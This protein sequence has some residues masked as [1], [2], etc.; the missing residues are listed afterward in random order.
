MQGH[1]H[2][3]QLYNWR[4]TVIFFVPPDNIIVTPPKFKKKKDRL[5]CGEQYAWIFFEHYAHRRWFFFSTRGGTFYGK[6]YFSYFSFFFLFSLFSTLLAAGPSAR[7]RTNNRIIKHPRTRHLVRVDSSTCA[8][9][10]IFL[11]FLLL[12]FFK[13]GLGIRVP[14]AGHWRGTIDRTECDIESPVRF[15]A[16]V[17]RCHSKIS[18]LIALFAIPGGIRNGIYWRSWYIWLH[19]FP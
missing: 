7:R 10:F 16:A 13:E 3:I 18:V 4:K 19:D 17:G 11:L 9:L 14:T 5:L 6:L 8:F 2:S 1:T 15:T 12:L